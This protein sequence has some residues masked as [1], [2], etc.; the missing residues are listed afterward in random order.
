MNDDLPELFLAEGVAAAERI[1]S[2]A[3][4]LLGA[5]R[6]SRTTIR[7]CRPDGQVQLVAEARARGVPSMADSQTPGI[8][9]AGTYVYL[10]QTHQILVQRDCRTGEPAPPPSLVRDLHVYAQM[11]AP[12]IVAGAM[13]AT[14]SVH[15]QDRTRDWSPSDVRALAEAQAEVGGLLGSTRDL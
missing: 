15:Q 7:L 3:A 4:R 1:G 5:T 9:A 14:I 13:A 11:L 8:R 12:V 2:I 6:S 10:E